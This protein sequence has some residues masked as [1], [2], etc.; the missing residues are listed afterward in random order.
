D[1]EIA[2][3]ADY[4]Y[5]IGEMDGNDSNVMKTAGGKL[6]NFDRGFAFTDNNKWISSMPIA[7]ALERKL[8]ADPDILQAVEKYRAS[9]EI[10]TA[11][12]E[13]FEKAFAKDGLVRFD[14]MNERIDRYLKNRGIPADVLPKW[15]K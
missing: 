6:M 5:L 8:P 3:L 4:H 2:R 15:K 14:A 13:A 12:R 10:Q 11:V 1:A 7:R 9:G